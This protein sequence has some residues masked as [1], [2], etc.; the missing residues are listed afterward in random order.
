MLIVGNLSQNKA[1]IISNVPLSKLLKA[2]ERKV[3]VR[4][5]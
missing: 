1:L 4:L 3:T 5:E 2:T